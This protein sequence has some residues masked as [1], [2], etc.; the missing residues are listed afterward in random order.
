M[1]DFKALALA[2]ISIQKCEKYLLSSAKISDFTN[3]LSKSIGVSF[4]YQ[5]SFG[6]SVITIQFLSVKKILFGLFFS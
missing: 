4:L 3:L 1:F 5:N 6:L 2:K